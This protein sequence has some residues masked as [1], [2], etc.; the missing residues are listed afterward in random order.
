[1]IKMSPHH[2]YKGIE[3]GQGQ[4]VSASQFEQRLKTNFGEDGGQVIDKVSHGCAKSLPTMGQ[5]LLKGDACHV[6]IGI[7][8][9]NKVHGHIEHPIHPFHVGKIFVKNYRGYA[10]AVGIRLL[11]Y[12][13][14]LDG[15]IG[16]MT[17]KKCSR[18]HEQ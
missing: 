6:D 12:E 8:S 2:G 3:V 17:L 18:G 4:G 14:P 9:P 10:A 7:I 13:P 11:P 5:K 1:M 16:S 15:M